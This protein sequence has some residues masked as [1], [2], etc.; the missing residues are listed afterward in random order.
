MI[1]HGDVAFFPRGIVSLIGFHQTV[2]PYDVGQRYAGSSKYT[3]RKMIRLASEGISSLSVAPL[4]AA[5]GISIFLLAL[6]MT[7][8]LYISI[9][10]ISGKAIP[11]WASIAL[12]LYALFGVNFLILGLLGEYIGK[13]YFQTLGRPR[14]L[15]RE[16][17]VSSGT[18]GIS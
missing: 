11:G 15:V 8:V 10:W 1:Q 5:F 6:C 7:M 13:A 18:K 3:M 17:I 12:P 16:C 14:Y 4:R 2:I 9:V